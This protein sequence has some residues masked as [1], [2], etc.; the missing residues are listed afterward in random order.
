MKARQ[1]KRL[2]AAHALA[3]LAT[4][5]DGDM[6]VWQDM[7]PFVREWGSPDFERLSQIDDL[8]LGATIEPCADTGLFVGKIIGILGAHSQGATRDETGDNLR[9]VLEMLFEGATPK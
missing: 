7:R 1:R 5:F 2:I 4:R 3:D 8:A 9:E 6:T